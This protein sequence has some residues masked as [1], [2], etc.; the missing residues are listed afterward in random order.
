MTQSTWT[1]RKAFERSSRPRGAMRGLAGRTYTKECRDATD[2]HLPVP[3]GRV[4]PGRGGGVRRTVYCSFPAKRSFLGIC[5]LRG[6][7]G[8]CH[9]TRARRCGTLNRPHTGQAIGSHWAACGGGLIFG[10]RY[11]TR[12]RR[13]GNQVGVPAKASCTPMGTTPCPVSRNG[14]YL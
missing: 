14:I 6:P 2:S 13:K 7:H 1:W 9:S 10:P 4:H 12:C 3:G 8:L 11:L 5:E